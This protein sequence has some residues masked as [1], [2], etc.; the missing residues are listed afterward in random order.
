MSR[1]AGRVLTVIVCCRGA[2]VAGIGIQGVRV[3]ALPLRVPARAGR[4]EGGGRGVAR[5][6]VHLLELPLEEP[7]HGASVDTL[8]KR[9]DAVTKAAWKLQGGFK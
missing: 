6:F 2:R 8:Q 5:V 1:H 7:A 9:A 3:A 4:G